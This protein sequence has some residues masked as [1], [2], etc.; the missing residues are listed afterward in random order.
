MKGCIVYFSATGNTEYV[1]KAIKNEF[2]V[3]NIS[4]DLNESKRTGKINCRYFYE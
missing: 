2:E 1:A 3:K 4:C